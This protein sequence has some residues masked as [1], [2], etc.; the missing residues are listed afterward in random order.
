MSQLYTT[1]GYTVIYLLRKVYNIIQLY[2]IR[3]SRNLD[4]IV[5]QL[6]ITTPYT[7]IYVRGHCCRFCDG[8]RTIRVKSA[9]RVLIAII[10]SW[11]Q[12][13]VPN[14]ERRYVYR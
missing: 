2:K 8:I 10:F 4:D 12:G 13:L 7:A 1:A 14:Q 3:S 9:I 11:H 5:A 6:Y